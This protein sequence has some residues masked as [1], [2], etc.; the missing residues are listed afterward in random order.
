M[1]LAM[2]KEDFFKGINQ[3]E[4]KTGTYITKYPVFYREV[5]YLGLFLLAP[6][7]KIRDILPSKRMYPFRLTPWYSMFTITATEY[8]DS[9]VG[10]YNQ[11]SIGIPFVIDRQTPVFTGILHKAPEVPLIYTLHLPVT[12]EH[13]RVSGIEMANY[14]EFLS[15]IHFSKENNW[16]KCKADSEGQNIL[17]L[18]CRD[19]PVKPFPRQRVFTVTQKND[20]LLRSE[21]NFS[22]AEVGVSKKQSDVKLEFGD[23]PIGQKLKDLYSGKVLQYQYYPSGQAILSSPTESYTI[24]K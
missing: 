16:I 8:K 9:D 14:P 18:S 20:R 21:F 4:V 15:D 19:I 17:I 2:Q 10:S 6:L 3:I 13:S 11:V 5:S 12:T 24:L 1:K 23:H 22:D 7:K